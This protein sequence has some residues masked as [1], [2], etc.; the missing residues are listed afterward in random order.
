MVKIKNEV[1]TILFLGRT[2]CGSRNSLDYTATSLNNINHVII[3][4]GIY[5]DLYITKNID[6]EMSIP[7]QEKEWDFDTILN[8]HFNGDLEA[9]N[10]SIVLEQVSSMKLKRRQIGT[11]S[12][13][14]L[15]E[16]P[17]YDEDDINFSYIDKYVKAK[18]EYEYAIIPIINNN[19]GNYNINNI[20]T[21]FDGIF[22]V[23]KK[24]NYSTRLNIDIS[25]QKNKPT[26]VVNTL[27]RKYPFVIQNGEN[28]YYSGSVTAEF[29]KN[30]NNCDF[31]IENSYIY[32]EEFMD[33]LYNG[34]PKLLKNDDGRMWMISVI[35]SSPENKDTHPDKIS[36]SFNF[37]E[38]G[39]SNSQIDLYS[40]N[41]ID[42]LE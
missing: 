25:T 30:K 36:T 27:G 28:N 26:T 39:D 17:I 8:A 7:Y 9:G 23:D 10:I 18:V 29:Y 35:D 13:V 14:T 6:T 20:K 24:N 42:V 19:E 40:N 2:F 22:I 1:I 33:F 5:D 31:D 37:T 21:W 4:E 11:N 16:F 15:Y 12:W 34:K 38:I 3:K 41:F 32:R